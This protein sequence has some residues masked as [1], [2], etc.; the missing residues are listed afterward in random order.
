M[1]GGGCQRDR[2][3]GEGSICWSFCQGLSTRIMRSMGVSAF[4]LDCITLFPVGA[5][6]AKYPN[7][8]VLD[9]VAGMTFPWA[10][11]LSLSLVATAVGI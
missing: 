4:S 10:V 7:E 5:S 6:A 2:Y 11:M 9:I 1:R 8:E 3:M